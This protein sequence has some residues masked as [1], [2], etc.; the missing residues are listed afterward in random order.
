MV[1]RDPRWGWLTIFA[2][3]NLVCW[4][5]AAI[6]IGLV[7][8]D[9][10]DLGVE[11]LIREGQA[12]AV[13]VWE[14][15]SQRPPQP[16]AGPANV[17]RAQQPVQPRSA[18]NQPPATITWPA[19]ATP[20][21]IPQP[22]D[23]PPPADRQVAEEAA[24]PASAPPV[25]A[26]PDASPTS[27]P[28]ATLVSGPLLMANPELNSL[29]QLNAEMS[30]SAP[31]RAVQIR[32]QE[33]ALNRELATLWQNRPELPY[34]NVQ[35]DLKRDQVI[36]TGIVKLFGFEVNARITGKAVAQD[37]RPHFEITSVSVE[38]LVTPPL[39]KDQ[40][41]ELIGEAMHW[42]PADYPLCLEQIVLEETRA[43]V[44]GYRR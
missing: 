37:C 42:Y 9:K 4:V 23:R 1:R 18:Q 34:R 20:T 28:E 13:V 36:V 26:P 7:V 27:E 21:P 33:D 3:A 8:G 39:L 17:V 11:T 43:T 35:I 30:R 10:V 15:A 24:P 14:K 2:L 38:G 6:V 25:S 16:T 31:E 41:G 40:I 32:Y 5:G 44:Y 22:I 12:T 29:T 19:P